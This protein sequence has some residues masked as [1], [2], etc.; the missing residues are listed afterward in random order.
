MNANKYET[1][2]SPGIS[3]CSFIRMLCKCQQDLIRMVLYVYLLEDM[4]N[5]ARFINQIGVTLCRKRSQDAA[6]CTVGICDGLFLVTQQKK[7]EFLLL[8]EFPMRLYRIKADTQDDNPLL[9]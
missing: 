7:G 5:F 4:D 2:K 9:L 6:R 8:F 3:L 1:R